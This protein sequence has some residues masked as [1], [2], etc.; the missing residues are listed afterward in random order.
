MP[1]TIEVSLS[2]ALFPYR[3]TTG[4]HI[5]VVIDILR[6]TTSLISAFDHG[7]KAVIPV[8]TPEEA[9]SLKKKGYPVAAERDGLRLPFAD[10]GNSAADFDTPDIKG[11]TLVYSTTNGT[12]AMKLA[13][14]NGPVAAAAFTNLEAVTT[15]V[16]AR[17]MNTVILC[18]GWK[19]LFSIEDTLCAGAIAS[20]LSSRE[21]YTI[22]C[23]A[24]QMSVNLWTQAKA[25][26][27][28]HL[29]RTS[30]YERL[31]KLGVDPLPDYTVQLCISGAVPVLSEGLIIN[32]S[33]DY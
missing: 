22:E 27:K 15:W 23:D 29:M 18:S 8:S 12:V 5:T 21:G 10:Y 3:T 9:E 30:H 19:N 33:K 26:L 20:L 13:S 2:P 6:F 32:N 17:K 4:R 24:A 25:N 31:I 11:K 14:P 1:P 28:S 7:V 16:S